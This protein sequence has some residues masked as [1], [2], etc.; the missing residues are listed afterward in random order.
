MVK[1]VNRTEL[2]LQRAKLE[3]IRQIHKRVCGNHNVT[4]CIE[5]AKGEVK[6]FL[7]P[8]KV[9]KN[10]CS[11]TFVMDGVFPEGEYDYPKVSHF[12]S[13]AEGLYSIAKKGGLAVKLRRARPKDLKSITV[14]KP[15]INTYCD[16]HVET[17]ITFVAENRQFIKLDLGYRDDVK[18]EALGAVTRHMAEWLRVA[19]SD[20]NPRHM[21]CAVLLDELCEKLCA[22]F[23]K[24]ELA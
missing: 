20:V 14:R 16:G 9:L 3:D 10:G 7:Y 19:V 1:K 15:V 4:L 8:F 21:A 5:V 18:R 6:L 2:V 22:E 17:D 13:A 24:L 12:M 11:T 23:D